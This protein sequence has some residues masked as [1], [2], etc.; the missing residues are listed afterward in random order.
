MILSRF[1]DSIMTNTLAT[2]LTTVIHPSIFKYKYKYIIAY[3]GI[4]PSLI[5]VLLNMTDKVLFLVFVV[6]R[7]FFVFFCI[8]TCLFFS[9]LNECRICPNVWWF[10]ALL[11]KLYP[12]TQI[13]FINFDKKYIYI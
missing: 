12:F 2:G 1:L 5:Y 6:L 13:I 9:G 7:F 11:S 10:R 4:N 3:L 8:R